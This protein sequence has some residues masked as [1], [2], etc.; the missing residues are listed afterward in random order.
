M[1]TWRGQRSA[2]H[3][4]F[5]LLWVLGIKHA[6]RLAR[7]PSDLQWA[8]LPAEPSHTKP[9]VPFFFPCP[10]TKVCGAFSYKVLPLV[11]LSNCISNT[12]YC[13]GR[14]LSTLAL[15]LSI[16][17]Y[18]ASGHPFPCPMLRCLPKRGS[19]ISPM[20]FEI[21]FT[22]LVSVVS[23]PIGRRRQWWE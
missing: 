10:I 4:L 15:R 7:L 20:V 17:N 13:L 12:F 16:K 1:H 3:E 22:V 5:S 2:F 6:I 11:L 19:I 23:V 14:I 21:L 8:F 18:M 9:L